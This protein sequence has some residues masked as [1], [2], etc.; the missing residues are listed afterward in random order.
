MRANIWMRTALLVPVVALLTAIDLGA[1]VVGATITGTVTDPS[2]AVAVDAVV[3]FRNTETGIVTVTQTNKAGIYSTPNLPPGKYIVLSD[4]SGLTSGESRLTLTVGQNQVL[5]VQ[6]RVADVVALVDVNASAGAVELG[7][8]AISQV[9]DGRAARELPL[10]GRDW[11]QLAQLEPNIRLIRTQPSGNG[12]NNRGNRGFGSQLTIGGARPQQNNYRLD[13]ISLNDY[14]NSSPGTTDGLALG[15]EAIAQFQVISSNYSAAYGLTSGGVISAITR[16]G[17]NDFHGSAYEFF[18]H[19]ALEAR[20]YFDDGRLPFHRHQFG[21]AVGGPIVRSRT[22]FF[23][24]YE[25]RRESTTTTGIATVP[26]QAARS[27][28]LASGDITVDPAVQQYL[29]LFG[30]PNGTISGDTGLYT[31]PSKAVVPENFVTLRM[32]HAISR[33][34]RLQ[35]TY[36]VDKGSTTQPDSLNVVLNL[37]ETTRRV[38]AI[39]E[40][41]I[42]GS[43]F[44]NTVRV[45]MNRVV[46]ATLQTAPGANPLGSDPSLGIASGLHAPVIQVP[47]LTSFSGG[48]NG[49]SF[50]N[51]WFTSWQVYD[52]A[53]WSAGKHS[54][55]AGFAWQRIHSDFMLAANPN[56]VFRFNTLTD[57]LSN[58]PA[59]L[60]LQS[61]ALTPR[62]MRQNVLGVYVEDDYRPTDNLSINLGLRYEP[63]SVPTEMNGKLANLRTLG[64]AQIHTGNPLFRNPTLMNVAPRIG[65][66]WDPLRTG[67]TVIRGGF[68]LFDVLPLTYQFNLMQV[69][70]APFQATASS[71]S[72]P[73]G[74]FPKEAA[75]LVRVASTLR[76]SF[77]EFAPKRNY[78]MQWNVSAERDVSRS[79]AVMVGYMGSRGV[80][81]AMR[82][83]D[84]NGVIPSI[85]PDG[86]VWPCAGDVTDGVCGRPGG[87]QRF[88]AAYG[89][90][91]GQVWNGSSS[92]NALLLSVRRRYSAGLEAQLSFTWSHSEDTGSSVG[93]GGPFLN[94][95]SGQF[96]FAPMRA[97]SDFHV[98][99]TLAG[100]A[101]WEVPF[102]R[103][104]PWGG[105]QVGA[106]LNMSDGLPFTPLIAGDA[107]GQGNQSLFNVPDRLDVPGCDTAVNPGNPSQY[108]NLSC[109]A[110]P[111]P[112]TRFGNA[113][114]NSLIGPGLLTI[115][116]SLIKNIHV[117][118][119]GPGARL[120]LRAELFNVANRANFAAPL[121]N[122]RLF[123]ATGNAVSFAGRITTLSTAPRQLQFGVKLMW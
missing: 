82:T 33:R 10:N 42:F 63:A 50:G 69:S 53:F 101:S 64:S 85:T 93:S 118:G 121:A 86:L 117:G 25:G 1:Q 84:A 14:A 106:V 116:A 30:Q 79:V 73:P 104:T 20:G 89:Q 66:A 87:G 114:R 76:T 35:G 5:N 120:Q 24:N 46:A 26:T 61:G 12:V 36:M 32:D 55:K 90:I 115:D 52:D 31:F 88:N 15:A 80:R 108:I 113:G 72:L 119:L 51:Y 28:H 47:G 48:L 65:I 54:I 7:T 77:I 78:V 18:R 44:V 83:T 110:F 109:F 11:T 97:R 100:S 75:A 29:G 94:S 102:G 81:N 38:V 43:Q 2:G 8:A 62:A 107:L 98:G 56:G 95:V 122:N 59:S 40:T 22:F 19:D 16:S 23:V 105:W 91:D 112:S 68:G 111:S 37:N 13:G 96:L 41:H 39:E 74:S 67:R 60:Q 92:Y 34:D 103:S 17:T 4:S 21:L 57:F 27:G 71:S 99:R 6:M 45:G 9:V 58:R 70:A 123:D 49:T 3:T